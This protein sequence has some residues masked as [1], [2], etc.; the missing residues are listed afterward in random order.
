MSPKTLQYLA[1]HISPFGAGRTVLDVGAAV[2]NGGARRWFTERGY[3]YAGGDIAPGPGVDVVLD[4]SC[5]WHLSQQYDCIV[6]LNTFE[7]VDRPW[8]LLRTMA[9]HLTFD[10][11]MLVVAPFS[12]QFHQHP[13]D[14][15]R[16]TPDGMNV[17]A[18]ESGLIISASYLDYEASA[19]YGMLSDVWWLVARR[20]Y[21]EAFTQFK[22]WPTRMPAWHC[23]TALRKKP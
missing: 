19:T 1:R 21:R 12:F 18:D 11:S 23:V 3:N 7:H 4:V 6:S 2:I 5:F 14:C 15:W 22:A 10:G 8:L 20:R 16:Y 17:L 9:Q 13:V